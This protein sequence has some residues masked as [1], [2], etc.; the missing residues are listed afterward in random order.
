M[1]TNETHP[2]QEDLEK[3]YL[4][5][6]EDWTNTFK[7]WS[8]NQKD[9]ECGIHTRIHTDAGSVT[10]SSSVQGVATGSASDVN[11]GLTTYFKEI[12]PSS[13]AQT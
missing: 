9:T 10:L 8:G 7:D 1:M 4:L 3:N 5:T 12:P 13:T 2:S 6:V 11:I